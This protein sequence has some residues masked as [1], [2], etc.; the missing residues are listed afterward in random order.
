MSDRIRFAPATRAWRRLTGSSLAALLLVN[1]LSGCLAARQIPTAT[2]GLPEALTPGSFP[3]QLPLVTAPVEPPPPVTDYRLSVGDMIEIS[4]YRQDVQQNDDMRRQ[5]QVRPDGKI[6][7][8]FIGDV[9]ASGRTVEEMRLEIND[10]LR[11]YFRSPEVVV[12][13]IEAARKRGYVLGEVAEQGVRELKSAKGDTVLDAIFLSRGLT[14]KANADRAFVLRRNAVIPVELGE[15]L[16]RG[17]QSKNIVLESED[18]VYVPEAVE[19]RVFVVGHVKQPGAFDVSRP[20]PL[21]E[22]IALASDFSPSAKRSAVKIIRGGLPTGSE[23]PEVVTVD[24]ERI[25]QGASPDVYVQRGDIVLVPA[26]IL[27]QWNEILAQLLPSLQTLFIATVVSRE[28]TRPT[29]RTTIIE[30]R[31]PSRQPAPPSQ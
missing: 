27:G 18:V 20:I 22:A 17:D 24:A 16:F 31:P 21:T 13:V 11:R 23:L 29:E 1:G 9:L 7:Y 28:L 19:Q 14:R 30:S 5:M 4:L 2:P 25:R 26:T 15:L 8:F 6:S 10:R 3:T 12:I